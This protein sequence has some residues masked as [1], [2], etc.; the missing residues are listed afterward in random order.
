MIFTKIRKMKA[1]IADLETTL[2]RASADIGRVMS[3][4]SVLRVQCDYSERRNAELRE[5]NR[6]LELTLD[7]AVAQMEKTRTNFRNAAERNSR[8]VRDMNSVS[9][10]LDAVIALAYVLIAT[11]RWNAK[12]QALLDALP[13]TGL[14][15]MELS[16]LTEL[17]D[18][19]DNGGEHI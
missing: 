16:E 11:G 7:A 3:D 5:Q 14:A 19:V 10:R 2:K 4:C 6:A 18:E 13:L 1:H 17:I 12:T 8:L 15:D 9:N